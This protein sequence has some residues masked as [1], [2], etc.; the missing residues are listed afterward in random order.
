LVADG[1]AGIAVMPISEILT[2]KGVD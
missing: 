2:T 1:S